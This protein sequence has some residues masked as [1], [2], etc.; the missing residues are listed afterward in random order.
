MT[1]TE[2]IRKPINPAAAFDRLNHS[3]FDGR[4]NYCVIEVMWLPRALG[5][6]H[7]DHPKITMAPSANESAYDWLATLAH[8]MAHYER[9]LEDKTAGHDERWKSIM[10]RI[11]LSPSKTGCDFV[12]D[13]PFHKVASDL[14]R[15]GFAPP[16]MTPG[17]Y[18]DMRADAVQTHCFALFM[19]ISI[20]S[21]FFQI[22]A[23]VFVSLVIAIVAVGV[24]CANMM[25][26]AAI[27]RMEADK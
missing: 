2:T 4:L 11:G 12:V 24:L 18:A 9:W 21:W 14:V 25:Y 3:L 1:P 8:E 17:N 10:R 5:Q 15:D 6:F 27:L 13:G 20:A 26:A 22:P 23:S 19:A 7:R 16:K